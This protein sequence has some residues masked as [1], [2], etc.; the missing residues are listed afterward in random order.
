[1]VER[2]ATTGEAY[3]LYVIASECN[4]VGAPRPRTCGE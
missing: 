4:G 2:V 1:M 3:Q